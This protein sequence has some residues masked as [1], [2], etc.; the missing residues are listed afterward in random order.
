MLSTLFHNCKNTLFFR[1]I[2]YLFIQIHLTMKK[3][4]FIQNKIVFLEK[5]IMNNKYY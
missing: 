1:I 3:N 4:I 2:I 5:V